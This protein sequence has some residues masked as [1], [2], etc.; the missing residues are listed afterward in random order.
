MSSEATFEKASISNHS[1]ETSSE[2]LKIKAAS[3]KIQKVKKQPKTTSN[4]QSKPKRAAVTQ[5]S[6]GEVPLEEGS[7]TKLHRATEQL[8]LQEYELYQSLKQE[9]KKVTKV[10]MAEH[11]AEKYYKQF[12]YFFVRS[13]F[14]IVTEFYKEKF[15]TF[16]S[17]KMTRLKTDNFKTWQAIVKRGGLNSTSKQEIDILVNEFAC[18]VF[19]PQVFEGGLDEEEKEQITHALIMV[20]FSHR[21]NKDDRFILEAQ[22]SF[23]SGRTRNP[24]DFTIV[25]DVMYKYSKKALDRFMSFP[26]QSF[27]LS[28]F[29]LS[30]EGI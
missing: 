15:Q 18:T 5:K 10:I 12:D 2:K 23:T 22:E 26:I 7:V 19:G 11:K 14:R 17:E 25:R 8:T 24:I 13:N 28:A 21:H 3:K 9:H 6:I 16:Y 1:N 29:A 4:P 20:V 27:F 30:D